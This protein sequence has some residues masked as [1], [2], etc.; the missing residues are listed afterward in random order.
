M[1][2]PKSAD[3]FA[4]ATSKITLVAILKMTERKSYQNWKE[5]FNIKFGESEK[6][7]QSEEILHGDLLVV[8]YVP[9]NIKDKTE[10]KIGYLDDKLIYWKIEN[11]KT[12][13]FNKQQEIE[14]F[15]R[16]D[17]TEGKSY[18]DPGLEFIENNIV[19]IEKQFNDGLRG[20]EI[21]YFKNGEHIK[22][23]VFSYY[24]G[25][26]EAYP[27]TI[28]F[29]NRSFWRKLLDLFTKNETKDFEILEIDLKEIFSGI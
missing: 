25:N 4:T 10:I 24:Y 28:Y 11:P 9:I 16:Y 22:S 14:Y 6:Y 1:F 13:G 5:F 8:K 17:F 15:Y 3:F 20:K 27:N 26:L 21:Q 19:A 29:Q 2:A 18:G 7:S 23:E 12:R